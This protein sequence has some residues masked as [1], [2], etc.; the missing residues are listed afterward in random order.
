MNV[1]PKEGELKLFNF[2]VEVRVSHSQLFVVNCINNTVRIYLHFYSFS[3][4]ILA[5][6][7]HCQLEL[8]WF[9]SGATLVGSTWWLYIY[10]LM[11]RD[12]YM[13]SILSRRKIFF[14]FKI[15]MYG[16]FYFNLILKGALAL[17]NFFSFLS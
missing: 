5:R 4:L 6:P 11:K 13:K 9:C 3:P 12:E 10:G 1:L 15:K 8:W 17:Y 7:H 2:H 14:Y 16:V